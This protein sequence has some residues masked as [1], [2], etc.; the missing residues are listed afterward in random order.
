[1]KMGN[2]KGWNPATVMHPATVLGLSEA[3]DTCGEVYGF[4]D[5]PQQRWGGQ[6]DV[7]IGLI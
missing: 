2:F 4:T 3:S 7:G 6:V 1:M 5:K